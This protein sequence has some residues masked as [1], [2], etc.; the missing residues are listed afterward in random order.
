[1]DARPASIHAL[2]Q[3][4]LAGPLAGLVTLYLAFGAV[5][6]PQGWIWDVYAGSL[7][8]R[9]SPLFDLTEFLGL[10]LLLLLARPSPRREPFFA[11]SVGTLSLYPLYRFSGPNDLVCRDTIPAL[12]LP[13]CFCADALVRTR[14]TAEP[15]RRWARA[16][17][18][19]ALI[20][21]ARTAPP[22]AVPIPT[23]YRFRKAEGG[24]PGSG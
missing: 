1:M 17:L 23:E 10:A 20:V 9:W 8:A 12:A 11:A 24:F 22:S 13:A 16:G 21:T 6:F 2:A 19:G 18:A 4:G 3:S 14:G 7:L 15:K 5:A